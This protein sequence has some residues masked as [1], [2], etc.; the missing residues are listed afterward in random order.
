MAEESEGERKTREG[1]EPRRFDTARFDDIIISMR[2]ARVEIV[3]D[4]RPIVAFEL[5]SVTTFF[6]LHESIFCFTAWILAS[7]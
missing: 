5:G 7:Q 6:E 4:G 1:A 2:F 3:D